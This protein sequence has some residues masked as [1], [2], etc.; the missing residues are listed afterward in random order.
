M[1][2][3]TTSRLLPCG[4]TF[5]DWHEVP[6]KAAPCVYCLVDIRHPFAPR[7]VGTIG[8]LRARFRQHCKTPV[9]KGTRRMYETDAWKYQVA[10]SG[11]RLAVRVLA[12]FPRESQARMAERR[13]ASRLRKGG[14]TVLGK[15]MV[16]EWEMALRRPRFRP[17]QKVRA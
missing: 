12:S 16:P 15:H 13:F 14:V 3:T 4:A 8:N 7:Y 17:T 6:S 10:L 2:R 11:G 1:H 5:F 9:A